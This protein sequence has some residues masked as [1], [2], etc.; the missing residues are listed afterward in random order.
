MINTV[1]IKNYI[2]K[3]FLFLET[4]LESNLTK[5][6]MLIKIKDVD[7]AIFKKIL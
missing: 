2:F 7:K 3:L 1:L 6:I 5:I 4:I